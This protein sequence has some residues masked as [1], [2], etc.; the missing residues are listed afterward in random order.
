EPG[1][2]HAADDNR[3]P[4]GEVGTVGEPHAVAEPHLAAAAGKGFAHRATLADHRPVALVEW[5]LAMA[6]PVPPAI[7]EKPGR[8]PEGRR[9]RPFP[10]AS[11]RGGRSA[12]GRSGSSLRRISA[13]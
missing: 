2:A 11:T 12:T 6:P 10:S 5:R 9:D 3:R 1:A 7:D 8:A 4:L 13:R